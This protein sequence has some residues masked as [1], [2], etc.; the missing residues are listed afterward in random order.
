MGFCRTISKKITKFIDSCPVFVILS[1]LLLYTNSL[2]NNAVTNE[3]QT[4]IRVKN[5]NDKNCK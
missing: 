4:F 2:R 3:K 5:K 1:L